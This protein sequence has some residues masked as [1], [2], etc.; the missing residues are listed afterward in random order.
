MEKI[1]AD[2]LYICMSSLSLNSTS[3]NKNTRLYL[4]EING[5]F[6]PFAGFCLHVVNNIG[7]I[8]NKLGSVVAKRMTFLH[9]SIIQCLYF[10]FGFNHA[11]SFS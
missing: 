5:E 11:D 2:S 1:R 3:S 10:M 7:V 8:N 6:K 9:Y 4:G